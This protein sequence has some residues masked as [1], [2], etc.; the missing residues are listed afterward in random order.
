MK[1]SWNE[2]SAGHGTGGL[3]TWRLCVTTRPPARRPARRPVALLWGAT[4]GSSPSGQGS[5][6]ADRCAPTMT[7]CLRPVYKPHSVQR[8]VR[9]YAET[10]SSP[11]PRFSDHLSGQ[12]TRGLPAPKDWTE[13]AAPS[14]LFDLALDGGC[15]AARIAASAGG[16]LRHLFT[17][18]GPC[19]PAV[20]FCGPIRQITPSRDFPGVVPCRVRTFLDRAGAQPRPL[21][22]PEA[23]S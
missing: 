16:L 13:R 6:L 18:T 12:S 15:L 19:G 17:M 21:N 14:S 10:A 1:G 3:D 22:R 8:G 5:A 2:K 9:V 20:C 11:A 23:L 4:R 7:K